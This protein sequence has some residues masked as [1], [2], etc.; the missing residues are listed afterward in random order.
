MNINGSNFSSSLTQASQSIYK[1]S[2]RIAS[3]KQ[4]NRATDNA[5]GLAISNQLGTQINEFTQSTRNAND[6]ISMLQTTSASLS[7]LTEGIQRIRELALQ[8]S[9]G[10][11]TNKDRDIINNEALQIIPELSHTVTTSSFNGK[12]I[13][14]G[15][16]GLETQ[17]GPNKSD[18]LSVNINDFGQLFTDLNI[19][20]LNFST[21]ESAGASLSVLDEIQTH[22]NSSSSK[23]GAG[24][25][26]LETTINTLTSSVINAKESRSRIQDS[27]IAKEISEMTSNKVKQ[28][29]S[30]AMQV[31]ANQQSKSV[32]KL[33]EGL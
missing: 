33:L 23:V 18:S 27:D 15:N 6:S 31:Q 22:I 16:S 4:I 17:I 11:L 12:P 14:S 24:L 19:E 21:A 9:N 2:E 3:G 25:N 10:T 26:R 20:N 28:D 8:A 5:A 32:L 30:I 29:V 7:S 13:L 1:A